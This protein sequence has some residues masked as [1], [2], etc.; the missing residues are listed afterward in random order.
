M[1]ISST[2]VSTPFN[3][4]QSFF[5]DPARVGG[6]DAIYV[7]SVDL[8]F[9]ALPSSSD[10]FSLLSDPGVSVYV[11]PVEG[12]AP[13]LDQYFQLSSAYKKKSELTAS[14]SSLVANKFTFIQPIN[15]KTGQ[16]YAILLSFDGNELFVPWTAIA[17]DVDVA[18]QTR[19][20]LDSGY[21]D[22]NF[23]Q[24]TNGR[25]LTAIK[26]TDLSFRLNIAKFTDLD[27]EYQIVNGDYEF[28]D[29]VSTS[30]TGTF[31]GGEYAYKQASDLTGTI[32]VTKGSN[33][34]TGDGTF[35]VANFKV[36]DYIIVES[37]SNKAA[38]KVA[39]ITSNTSLVM[40]QVAPFTNSVSVHKNT[41]V[42]RIMDYEPL[43][44]FLTLYGSTAANAA[45]CF[46]SG[47]TLVGVDSGATIEID[48]VRN[49]EALRYTPTHSI[50]KPSKTA[51]TISTTFANSTYYLSNTNTV[52][53]Q[54]NQQHYFSN[55]P[56]V[57]AS[58]SLEVQNS[59]NLMANT[60]KSV[61]E[62]L[63]FTSNS[64]YTSPVAA[65]SGLNFTLT[66]ADINND[67]TNEHT[68]S[69]NARSKYISQKFDL[70]EE[71]LAED[72]RVFLTA[73][74]PSGTTIEVYAKLHHPTDP[75]DFDGK[76][77]TKLELTSTA[78]NTQY[79]DPTNR[80]DT[81]NLEYAIPS[82]FEGTAANGTFTTTLSS[83]VV[84]GT[85]S[86]V[87]TY[88]TAGSLVR[89]YNPAIPENYFITT[90]SSSNTTAFIVKGSS[91]FETT[92]ANSSLVSSGMNVDV[93]STYAKSAFIDNQNFNIARYHNSA[94]TP[95][96]GYRTFSI[97]I[98]MLST[99]T[100]VIPIVFDMRTLALS[101]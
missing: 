78:N 20:S 22:G 53:V 57:I 91:P 3:Y 90:V 59:T 89:V 100:Y 76:D 50:S 17:G 1:A 21:V 26:N 60:A 55:Y 29:V 10:N 35:F 81:V 93:I 8:F 66:E 24:I 62:S 51:A 48:A 31:L 96:I 16:K 64:V 84:V 33:T 43:N 37:G 72:L 13:Q 85:T 44:D 49:H 47:D 2:P 12:D 94:G 63:R 30:R 45:F 23:F 73:Y 5:I 58:R 19:V 40:D 52:E 7:T 18:L 34:V 4:A 67:S 41:P 97:K 6:V 75:D 25:V 71:Q 9:K 69:G 15:L 87:N 79:S 54:N 27:V 36:G 39:S 68:S 56:A 28:F 86:D 14:T 46:A 101:A 83:N 92:V 74:R 95:F 98:V 88:V 61:R 65:I 32:S 82:Y 99:T 38:A 80:G 77:W 42:G 11:C 70:S